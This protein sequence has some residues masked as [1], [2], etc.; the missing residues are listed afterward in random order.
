MVAGV[1]KLEVMVSAGP[2]VPLKALVKTL[3]CLFQLLA[4]VQ[5]PWNSLVC[6]QISPL[7]APVFTWSSFLSM[8]VFLWPSYKDINHWIW[9]HPSVGEDS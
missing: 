8:C 9:A 5:S 4:V 1:Q 3:P 6:S 2:W 7:S